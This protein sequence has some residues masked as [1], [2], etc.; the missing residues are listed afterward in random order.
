[1]E[2]TVGITLALAISVF[3][4]LV[5]FDRDRASYPLVMI[6]IASYYDLFAIMGQSI[7]ALTLETIALAAF[8]LVSIVGFKKDLWLVAVAL[9]VHGVFDYFHARLDIQSWCARL[10]PMFCLSYISWP[11]PISRCC[12]SVQKSQQALT[13]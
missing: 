5:G 10:V 6:V 4:S 9:A 7:R 3:A 11:P 2:Y 1:M 13:G 8:V 12:L